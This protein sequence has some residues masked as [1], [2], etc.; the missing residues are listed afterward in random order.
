MGRS[1]GVRCIH[2]HTY[3]YRES[4]W[5]QHAS[6][7]TWH[8]IRTGPSLPFL[9]A[10]ASPGILRSS[11]AGAAPGVPPTR[12]AAWRVQP[13][14]VSLAGHRPR[15]KGRWVI[16]GVTRLP[17]WDS[18]VAIIQQLAGVAGCVWGSCRRVD[19][20]VLKLNL[21]NIKNMWECNYIDLNEI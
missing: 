16:R 9:S 20:K 12:S 3:I 11:R 13:P 4:Y 17:R 6:E 10:H 2:T 14:W 19:V 8:F 5:P 7:T 1:A 15:T 18:A 21:P